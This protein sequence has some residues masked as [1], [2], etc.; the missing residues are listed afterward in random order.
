MAKLNLLMVEMLLR[1]HAAS[2]P[3]TTR[4]VDFF[5]EM[6]PPSDSR[7]LGYG[8]TSYPSE[9]AKPPIRRHPHLPSDEWILTFCAK[10]E[11]FREV[12]YVVRICTRGD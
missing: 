11:I 7:C 1:I 4:A 5:T 9:K 2:L 8:V 6:S 10:F 12:S 3:E